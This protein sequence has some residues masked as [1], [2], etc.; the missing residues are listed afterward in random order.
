MSYVDIMLWSNTVSA[1]RRDS[2]RGHINAV[3]V[4]QPLGN[5][6]CYSRSKHIPQIA[7]TLIRLQLNVT[8][9][10]THT[11][12]HTPKCVLYIRVDCLSHHATNACGSC[13]QRSC[14]EQAEKWQATREGLPA[15]WSKTTV[16]PVRT[17]A[18]AVTHCLKSMYFV[19]PLILLSCH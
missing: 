16:I 11:H 6:A 12:T 3:L 15:V 4:I 5:H 1:G 8:S 13:C 9:F 2:K 19:L 10:E 7:I 17:T 18:A 14:M